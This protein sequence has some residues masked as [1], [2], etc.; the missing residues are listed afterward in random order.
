MRLLV[1]GGSAFVGRAVVDA[2]LCRGWQVTVF[3]RGT[4]PT[5]VEAEHIRGDRTV[6]ADLAPLRERDWDMVVDTWRYAPRAVQA[7]CAVLAGRV[8]H[9]GYVSSI[10][11]YAWPP[12]TPITEDAD[13][14]KPSADPDT[15]DYPEAKSSAESAIL[16]A[17]GGRTLLARAGLILGPHEY[18]GRLPWW[19]LRFAE[20]DRVLAPEPADRQIQYIDARDLADW[21]LDSAL[22]GRTGPFNLV[23]P[24]GHATMGRLL[25][26]CA[27]AAGSRARMVWR[28]EQLL[29]E[30]GVRPWVGLPIWLPVADELSMSYDI[31]VAK[32]MAAGLTCRPLGRTVA[33]TWEWLASADSSTTGQHKPWLSRDEEVALLDGR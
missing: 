7:S 19:L 23:C 6:L 26:A 28:S 25:Q 27:E 11:V 32:S 8:G 5:P 13:V 12:R 21:M 15:D 29:L 1:L 24:R 3:N 20:Y 14:V 4:V 10:S 9:Y 2:G 16:G 33:D 22:A 18:A 17:F 31:D 30:A